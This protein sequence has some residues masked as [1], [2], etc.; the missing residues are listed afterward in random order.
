MEQQ[1]RY[2]SSSQKDKRNISN[3]IRKNEIVH[4]VS[5][6]KNF[7]SSW[8]YTADQRGLLRKWWKV[9]CYCFTTTSIIII[10]T[11]QFIRSDQH[12]KSFENIYERFFKHIIRLDIGLWQFLVENW[13]AQTTRSKF[14]TNPRAILIRSSSTI[15]CTSQRTM[16][17]H[18][19]DDENSIH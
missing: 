11:L 3:S 2:H 13:R 9:C 8:G 17:A 18:T 1:D 16:H 12:N 10:L 5:N 4:N 14:G 6:K 15:D 7:I 19:T